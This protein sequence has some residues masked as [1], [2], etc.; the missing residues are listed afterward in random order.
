R[1][2]RS[3]WRSQ[4]RALYAKRFETLPFV[5]AVFLPAPLPRWDV[6]EAPLRRDLRGLDPR[7]PRLD[8]RATRKSAQIRIGGMRR[9]ERDR[10]EQAPEPRAD[11]DLHREDG[12]SLVV[13]VHARFVQPGEERADFDVSP[14]QPRLEGRAKPLF[15]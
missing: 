14:V 12:E 13:R 1:R 6:L 8:D 15:V 11:S 2:R 9:V 3:R 7:E 10:F 4:L 5:L